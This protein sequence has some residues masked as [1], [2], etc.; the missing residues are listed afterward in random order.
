MGCLPLGIRHAVDRRSA[1]VLRETASLG[2]PIAQTVAA[3]ARK[4]HQID[5]LHVGPMLEMVDQAPEGF[6]CYG[7]VNLILAHRVSP[8]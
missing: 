4:P 2:H 8:G 6:G 1:L 5:I 7:I 3:K